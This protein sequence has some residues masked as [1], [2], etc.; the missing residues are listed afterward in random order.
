MTGYDVLGDRGREADG[1]LDGSVGFEVEG[2]GKRS[3]IV[4]IDQM[5][6]ARGSER[7]GFEKVQV[8]KAA[9]DLAFRLSVKVKATAMFEELYRIEGVRA[10]YA[11]N[12]RAIDDGASLAGLYGGAEGIKKR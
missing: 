5:F 7:G 4:N 8:E 1:G 12:R 6:R 9:M 3:G 11:I 2:G 10:G